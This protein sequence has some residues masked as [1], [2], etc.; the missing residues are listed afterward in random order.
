VGEVAPNFVSR[1][2]GIEA[3]DLGVIITV[4]TAAETWFGSKLVRP[5]HSDRSR[6]FFF[7][8]LHNS[9]EK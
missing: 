7:A 8:N 1:F 2:R 5:I 6:S 3:T 4:M 9:E